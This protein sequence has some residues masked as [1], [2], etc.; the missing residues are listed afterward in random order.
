[1]KNERVVLISY[2]LESLTLEGISM[3]L[4]M[5]LLL[6]RGVFETTLKVEVNL[7]FNNFLAS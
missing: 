6:F 3:L 5:F 7:W 4:L 1:L 2:F